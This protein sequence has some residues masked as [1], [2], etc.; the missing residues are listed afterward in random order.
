MQL[1]KR[2]MLRNKRFTPVQ[3]IA[4]G[5]AAIIL[6]GAFL[7]SLPIAT[8]D[9][10]KTPFI[11]C[12]FTSTSAVCVTGL[13][14][15]D[16]G[17]Y[18]SYFGKTVIMLLIQI[19]GLGFMSFA[20]L[21]ALIAGKRITLKER[22]LIRESIS[23]TSLQGIVRFARYILTFTFS[24]ELIGALLLS[25]QFIPEFGLGKG[26]YYSIFHAVSAFC[27]AGFDLMGGYSSVTGYSGNALIIL[28]LSAL[29]I[30]GGLG[31]YVWDDLYNYKINRRLSLQ[32]KVVIS[33]SLF[34]IVF[35]FVMFFIFEYSNPAT[36]KEMSMKDKLLSAFFASVSPRTA[37]F[38]SIDLAGMSMASVLLTI[39]LMFIG[40]SPGSTAGGI[41]TSTA[42]VLL[43]TVMSVIKGREDTEVFRKKISKETVYKAFAVVVIALGL[44]FTVTILLTITE[45]GAGVP[46]EQYLFEATSAF[47]TV[48]LTMGLTQK[49]TA[50]GKIIVA[51]TMYAG[52]I[53]PLTLLVAIAIRS[54]NKTNSI[55]YP[56][57]KILVG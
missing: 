3:I 4:M 12:I 1:K 5:F 21:I 31:F 36:L 16:T 18:W 37:G 9:G 17:T 14:T 6:I 19:G 27:N 29:I 26:I 35:G 43:L 56:E 57:G 30:I 8:I 49:L 48:G 55:K 54:D 15:V 23:L 45:S 10:V 11:D 7:L 41:K 22:L 32:T 42:G 38:N 2:N 24:I 33:M 47:G 13:V 40:G 53:G 39:I 52:R 44:V 25:I 51:I 34:L 20:T 50:I 46:F 28:T